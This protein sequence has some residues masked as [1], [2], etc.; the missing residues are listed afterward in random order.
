M[1]YVDEASGRTLVRR[2][3]DAFAIAMRSVTACAAAVLDVLGADFWSPS[4]SMRIADGPQR[5]AVLAAVRLISVG[6]SC[7]LCRRA[8]PDRYASRFE[9]RVARGEDPSVG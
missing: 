7:K 6:R 3:Q 9:L 2:G 1:R 5:P 4:T 8:A